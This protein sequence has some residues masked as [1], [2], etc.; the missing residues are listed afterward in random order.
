MYSGRKEVIVYGLGKDFEDFRK[1][2]EKEYRVIGYSDADIGKAKQYSPFITVDEIQKKKKPVLIASTRYFDEIKAALISKGINE[3]L[4]EEG[5][6]ERLI[7]TPVIVVTIHGWMGNILFCYAFGQMLQKIHPDVPVYYNISWYEV[8]KCYAGLLEIFKKI[9]DVSLPVAEL[10]TIKCAQRQGNIIQRE[11]L[12]FEE[13]YL[14]KRQGF[15][16]GYWQTSKYFNGVK[17]QIREAYKFNEAFMSA[18]QVRMLKKIRQTESV[19]IWFRRGDYLAPKNIGCFGNICTKE[20]YYKAMS[21][22]KSRYQ[23]AEFFIFSND[24]DYIAQNYSEYN[25]MLYDD[26]TSD[27]K[28]YDMYL[29]SSCKHLIIANSTFSWWAAWLHG[30]NGTIIAPAKWMN[31]REDT[32]IWEEYWIKM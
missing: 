9:F 28:D 16:S 15:F 12:V 24:S 27:I 23:D 31:E 17:N 32:D 20:Y 8:N 26:D 4:I 14:N 5:G 18:E 22:M 25:L 10:E 2:I 30:D 19:A 1:T 13:K 21:Y 11:S 6:I 3:I 7:Q 29:M